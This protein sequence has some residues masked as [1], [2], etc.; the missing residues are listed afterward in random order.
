MEKVIEYLKKNGKTIGKQAQ[1]GDKLCIDIVTIYQKWTKEPANPGW[2]GIL[3]GMIDEY[4]NRG[5]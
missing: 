5:S 3:A 2:A 4:K 1:Q